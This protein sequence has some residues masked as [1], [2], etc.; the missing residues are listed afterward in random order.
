MIGFKLKHGNMQ[1]D[2]IGYEELYYITGKGEVVNKATGKTKSLVLD[3][4]TG[5]YKLQLWKN[6]KF[7][8]F[9]IHR[10]IAAHFIENPNNLKFVNHKDGNKV[11]NTLENLEWV[12]SKQNANHYINELHGKYRKCCF[13]P[14]YGI[15]FTFTEAAKIYGCERKH[16][17]DMVN[18]KRKNKSQFILA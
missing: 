8:C 6:N 18:G 4:N 16:M 14:E 7:K 11:N 13:L 9:F 12:T 2:L 3:S 15:Y 5:Y 17:N 1:K 10:L